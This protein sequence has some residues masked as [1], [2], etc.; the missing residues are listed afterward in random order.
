[1]ISGQSLEPQTEAVR[2]Q[3]LGVT[4]VVTQ[5]C[6][7]PVPPLAPSLWLRLWPEEGSGCGGEARRGGAAKE[8]GDCPPRSSLGGKDH[9]Q[10]VRPPLEAQAC[11]G[12]VTDR[13]TVPPTARPDR[14]SACCVPGTR[15]AWLFLRRGVSGPG[16]RSQEG[17]TWGFPHVEKERVMTN[18]GSAQTMEGAHRRS[19]KRTDPKTESAGEPASGKSVELSLPPCERPRSSSCADGPLPLRAPAPG[20]TDNQPQTCIL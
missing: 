8:S 14:A 19:R 10:R 16:L 18:G 20:H 17:P 5:L 13:R 6:Q 12:H 1:M 15:R 7:V 2:P 9:P 3:R 11:T 4:A